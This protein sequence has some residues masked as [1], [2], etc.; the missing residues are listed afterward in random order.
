MYSDIII[1][2]YTCNDDE[3]KLTDAYNEGWIKRY[4]ADSR[5]KFI[6]VYASPSLVEP[7]ILRGENLIV[8]C[9]ESYDKLSIKTY[10]MISSVVDFTK[11]KFLIKID[12]DLEYRT[13][14]YTKLIDSL[15]DDN[16]SMH[17]TGVK[18]VK[19]ITREFKRWLWNNNRIK[20]NKDKMNLF[21]RKFYW[22]SLR[23]KG[24]FMGPCY[25]LSYSL[26]KYITDYGDEIA[27][28]LAKFGGGMEDV[29]VASYY[30]Q[31]PYKKKNNQ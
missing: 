13:Y 26:C 11:F 31:F 5:V 8:K 3:K 18:K 21:N 28:I 24:F 19:I 23:P 25:S 10:K 1:C 4:K 15:L 17:Y 27:N 16:Q 2:L 9:E 30:K 29:M 7:W 20:Y 14:Q 6:N 22:T 12:C